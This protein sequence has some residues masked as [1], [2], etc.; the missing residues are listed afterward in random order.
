MM[1]KACFLVVLL[2]VTNMGFCHRTRQLHGQ[3]ARINTESFQL[4]DCLLFQDSKSR[5]VY[6]VF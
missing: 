4:S 2:L 6:A 1:S 3:Q 5:R